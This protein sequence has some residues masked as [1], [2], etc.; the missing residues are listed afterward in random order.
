V[1]RTVEFA[2]GSQLFPRI[3]HMERAV[4]DLARMMPSWVPPY[5]SEPMADVVRLL[6]VCHERQADMEERPFSPW[7]RA[8]E[9][10]T[11]LVGIMLRRTGSR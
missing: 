6:A 5:A 8:A 3:D 10:G 2:E 9:A 4:A 11:R 1:L 7:S